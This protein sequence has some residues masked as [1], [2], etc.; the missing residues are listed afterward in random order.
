MP[1]LRLSQSRQP[2]DVLITVD[3]NLPHQQNMQDRSLAVL[4]LRV[5]SNRLPDRL[6]F[7]PRLQAALS[8]IRPGEVVEI[9]V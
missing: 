8:H 1:R 7:V 5:G 4:L 9:V 3:T 6:P 2:S